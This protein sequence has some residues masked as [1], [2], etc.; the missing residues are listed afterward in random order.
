MHFVSLCL[1]S[2]SGLFVQL[3]GVI[4]IKL[5]NPLVSNVIALTVE[6]NVRKYCTYFI[7]RNHTDRAMRLR[8]AVNVFQVQHLLLYTV[9]AWLSAVHCCFV[10]LIIK[11]LPITVYGLLC[12]EG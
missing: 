11:L 3:S 8:P 1:C 5:C 2:I 9:Y 6:Q 10:S 4:S 7:K 12:L